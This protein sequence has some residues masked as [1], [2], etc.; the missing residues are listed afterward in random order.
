MRVQSSE[1]NLKL[2][3]GSNNAVLNLLCKWYA[4]KYHLKYFLIYQDIYDILTFDVKQ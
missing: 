2:Q 4:I 1:L 3:S